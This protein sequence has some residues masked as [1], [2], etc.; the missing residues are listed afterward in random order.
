MKL[1]KKLE[2]EIK[3]SY[4][5]YWDCYMRGDTR[6]FMTYITP[7]MH[8]TGTTESEVIKGRAAIHKF[9]LATKTQVVG[10]VQ[11]RNRKLQVT[12]FEKHFLI[13]DQFHL[14]LLI[15]KTW[16]FYAKFRISTIA[17][18]D[19]K[20]WKYIQ[21]HASIPDTSTEEG[22]TISF[23]KMSKENRELR[24]A[25]KRRTIELEDKNRELEIETAL[26]KV[27]AVAMGMKKADDMLS[28]CKTISHQLAQLGVKEI[29]NVQTAIFNESGGTYMN[30][31]YYAKHKKTIITETS[32]TNNKT[33][34][35]FALKM[36]KGKGE[37]FI[38]H[39]KGQ[40]V[41][42]WITYQK[43][44]NVFIDRFL[45]KASSLN[46]YW[47]SL[48]P[49]ALGISTYAPLS[50]EDLKLFSRFLNVFELSYRRYLDIERAEAQTRESQIQLALERVRAAAMAMHK[51]GD[52]SAIGKIIYDELKKLGFESI[53]NTEM[54]INNDRK[55]TVTSYH[56][57]EYGK[58]EVVE[59]GY[60]ENPVV[61]KWAN[62]LRKTEDAFVPV[63]IKAKEIKKWDQYRRQLGYKS[64]PGMAKAKAIYYYSYSIG[65]G[66]LSI[67][68]WQ[69]LVDEQVKLLERFRNVFK[70]S[71][72]RYIDI[73]KAEAQAREA[74][75]QLALERV[76]ARTMAMQKSDELPEAATLLFQQVQSLGMPAWS[77]G[78][79][80]W[81]ED[82]SAVTLWMS[83][84]GVLQPPFI[85]PTTEDEL[86]IEMRKGHEKG[87]LL[88]VVEMGG[89]KLQEHYKYMRTLPVVGEVLD[90][91]I[92]AGHPLPAFQVMHYAYFSKGY[93]LFI[94]YE[95]VPDAHDIFKRFASVFDQTYTRFLDL[96][97]AEAQAR[98]A[99]IE[100][101]LETIRSRSLS[102]QKSE[103]L[104]LVIREVLKK[105]EELGITMESRV[106]IIIELNNDRRELN[107]WVASPNFSVTH[108]STPYTKH[109]I[110][111]NLWNAWESGVDFYTKSYPTEVKN[112]YFNYLFEHSSFKDFENIDEIR[113]WILEQEFYSLSLVFEKNSSI[114]IANYTNIPLSKD[115]INIVKRFSKVFEQAYIRF[116][117]LQKAEAQTREAKIE[118]ALE[119]VRSRSLAMHKSEELSEL[120]AVLYEKMNELGV[121]SDGININVIKEGAK[122][123]ESWLAAPGQSYALCF[124][125]PYFN[126]PVI[127]EIMEA[128]KT[129]KELLTKV[130]SFEEKTSFFNYLYNNTDFKNL[131]EDRKK[132]VL[133]SKN[134]EVSIA[135]AKNTALSL[136]SYSGKV[137]SDSENEILKR[138]AKVFE[139]SYTRF[140]DLQK[141]EA[142][143]EEAR[144]NLIQIKAEKQKAE[145]A[146]NEL[147][148]TQKQLIQSE[149]MASLGE[150][151]A[152]IAHEIQ[153]PLNFVNNFS[154]VSKELL[155][156]MKDALEKGDAE[157][158]K[159]I[160]KDVIQNLEKINHHGRRADS[161]VKGMLQ[162]SRSS[163]GQKEPTDINALADEYLRL[164]YHGL[165]A[166]DKLFNAAMKTDFDE[167][168][169]NINIIPQD[170]GRVILNLITNAFYEVDKKKKQVGGD[171]AP[172]VIVSTKREKDSVAIRVK[173]NANGIPPKVL[174]K[175]FQPFFS[176]K[177]TGQGTGLGLSLSYDIVK[178]HGGEL[179][180]ETKEGDGTV[181]TIQL[182]V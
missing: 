26:E 27:R 47:H 137:F 35:A 40:K 52:L 33:H 54:I 32:Y 174:D 57:S 17:R 117:D 139:Q 53:R 78:Y 68:T 71:Y 62:D 80:I 13:F 31:E 66:A 94:T 134:W 106:A 110:L 146:L 89:K 100:V 9:I 59:I 128:I 115:E 74:Q 16:T 176:T 116:L 158:A 170:M 61:R 118:T 65:L 7:D 155:D 105:F 157:E 151:T 87:K 156:E 60:R 150:L 99:K 145:D 127:N 103:E 124:H 171:Y 153:N 14:Y 90:S 135:F 138:F 86:F 46:Y 136:H 141:A 98:E 123:F 108:A 72:Q 129:K 144:L 50:K 22:E 104:S 88:H 75:I 164:A 152:G 21:Q 161:I 165:R 73:A 119:R 48:G 133:E 112:S 30:Y 69:L 76:R 163:T 15:D 43:T 126:H 29:R 39:I 173:D 182:P 23:Q 64:D 67:S 169:G 131:P 11:M 58:Q 92:E 132:M 41:K 149:K 180:V 84:E 95:P 25:V 36:L 82:K 130:Y 83:S 178:A 55:E 85:A 120:V 102:M 2:K 42:D 172:T 5:E 28:I 51:P 167:S 19:G 147:Q 20:G 45:E 154:E 107:Q 143:A 4:I 63:S 109:I 24:D 97:K 3:E 179:K 101:A 10:K 49:V 142:H 159:E 8:L 175:I 125:V 177:P 37:I 111:D 122:D 160:A 96:Q 168:I 44:T 34:K 18:Q 114:G 6:K 91:I 181:F 1:T 70:L 81:N 140:L 38:T 77:A 79:C 56:H 162:H 113:L 148:V 121:L 166:K 93:L 12:S